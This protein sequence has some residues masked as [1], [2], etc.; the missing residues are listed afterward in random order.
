MPAPPQSRHI[1]Y[2]TIPVDFEQHTV[3]GSGSNAHYVA[4]N[5]SPRSKNYFRR[6]INVTQPSLRGQFR[7]RTLELSGP[8]VNQRHIQLRHIARS[9]EA[10][11]KLEKQY[12]MLPVI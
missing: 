12:F 6:E 9:A 8:F 11:G 1:D 4:M 10:R 7:G 5:L 3:R 2:S